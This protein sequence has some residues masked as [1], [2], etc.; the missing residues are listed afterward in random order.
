MGRPTAPDADICLEVTNR[1]H[2]LPPTPSDLNFPPPQF[3][4]S[5]AFWWLT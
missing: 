5:A 2:S 4:N 3:I 1:I